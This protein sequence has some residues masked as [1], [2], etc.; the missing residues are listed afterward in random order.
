MQSKTDILIAK[1]LS[2]NTSPEETKALM[3][4]RAQHA[5]NEQ[6]FLAA[7][8]AWQVSSALK[9][10]LVSDETAGWE[11]LMNRVGQRRKRSVFT[12]LRVA[13][14]VILL[15]CLALVVKLAIP[16][17]GETE[18]V[19]DFSTNVSTSADTFPAPVAETFAAE[20][21]PDST[22]PEFP[23]PGKKK[24]GKRK[25]SQLVAMIAVNSGDSA[26]VFYLP[27]NSKVYL[28]K[29]SKLVFPEKFAAGK[30]EVNLSGEAFFEVAE[31]NE[32]FFVYCQDTK[33]RVM[34]TSF[35]V[36][37]YESREVEVTVITGVVEVSKSELSSTK[38][39]ISAGEKVIYDSGKNAFV[40]QNAHKKDRWWKRMSFRT[41]IK[42][43]FNK[44]LQKNG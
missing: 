12:P 36:S 3:D 44:I 14:A 29:N 42:N 9:K 24:S 21:T 13:A 8:Q 16:A 41:R 1:Y 33:T 22:L 19:S 4:W 37:G 15:A 17:S 7:E 18:L 31:K 20:A 10:N 6:T 32:D 38:I 11:D 35:N 27:D 25:R 34:G 40:H 5:A 39:I 23:E 30:R 43:F 2:G 26:M 28:N